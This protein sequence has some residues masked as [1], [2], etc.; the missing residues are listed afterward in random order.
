MASLVAWKFQESGCSQASGIHTV[1][2]ISD[3]EQ[4]DVEWK[5]E[6]NIG[7]IFIFEK[8]VALGKVTLQWPLLCISTQVPQE[9]T[10]QLPVVASPPAG[11]IVSGKSLQAFT[12]FLVC[13]R[14][15]TV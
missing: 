4:P 1:K 13:P 11:V 9:L 2:G 7:L 15:T 10:K 14:L 5:M 3:S 6:S 8:V 12:W